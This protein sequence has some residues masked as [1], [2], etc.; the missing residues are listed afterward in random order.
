MKKLLIL[1]LFTTFGYSQTFTPIGNAKANELQITTAPTVT[2]ITKGLVRDSNGKVREQVL[3]SGGS[4]VDITASH[5]IGNYDVVNNVPELY[6]TTTG[7]PT[8][9]HIKGDFFRLISDGFMVLYPSNLVLYE[10]NFIVFDGITWQIFSKTYFP[11]LQDVLNINQS[12]TSGVV[13]NFNRGPYYAGFSDQG[14]YVG[15]N[16]TGAGLGLNKDYLIFFNPIGSETRLRQNDNVLDIDLLLPISSGT[17][18]LKTDLPTNLKIY[19]VLDYGAIADGTTDNTTAFASAVAAVPAGGTLYIPDGIYKGKFVINHDHIKIVG[20]K[21]PNYNGS[22]LIGGTIIKGGFELQNSVNIEI[23]NLGIDTR[24]IVI[25]DAIHGGSTSESTNLNYYIHDVIFLNNAYNSG[26]GIGSH[27][28]V[29]QTGKF[30]KI[31]K[32]KGYFGGHGIAIRASNVDINDVFIQNMTLSSL[33]LKSGVSGSAQNCKDVN[34]SNAIFNSTSNS[35]LSNL[36]IQALDAGYFTERIKINNLSCIGGSGAGVYLSDTVGNSNI[37]EIQFNNV[38]ITGNGGSA[39]RGFYFEGGKNITLTNCSAKDIQGFSF[40]NNSA[41]KIYLNNCISENPA[42]GNVTGNFTYYEINGDIFP[43]VLKSVNNLAD[44][45]NIATA[46]TN[47][48]LGSLATSSATIPTNTNQLTNGSGFI[49]GITSGNV[50]TALGFTPYNAT[51][52]S[53]FITSYTETDPTVKAISGLVKSNGTTISAAVANTDYALPNA[54]NTNYANDYRLANFVAGTNYLA[55]NGSASSLTGFP[56][57]N[58]NTTGTASTI[59]GNISKSQ[60]TDLVTDLGNKQNTISL[61]TTGSGAATFVSNVLNIPTPSGSTKLNQTIS[62][63]TTIA[64]TNFNTQTLYVNPSSLLTSYTVTL[65]TTP[66]DGDIVFIAFGGTIAAN[67]SVV[68]T[69]TINPSAGNSIYQSIT[70]LTANGGDWF[71]YVYNSTNSTFYRQ[72]L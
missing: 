49:T 9:G 60:V 53:G 15:D 68:S 7:L 30:I 55:P 39:D 20:S 44:L 11:G 24:G 58:Q 3:A 45:N 32:V 6:N 61:T 29:F 64:L 34:V 65:P 43:A 54:T 66:S 41:Q 62:S 70:P 1:L 17:L 42:A 18:A 69:L 50:T 67:N 23:G 27:G 57:F 48:G 21:S 8:S 40:W 33:I 13:A 71:K 52:P 12:V 36:S 4:G 26:T 16:V 5:Y 31:E 28:I 25:T 2:G 14:F 47:L 63:G 10:G 72:N 56:T 37:S 19:N 22:I 46:R 35:F 59:T 51:N 38:S